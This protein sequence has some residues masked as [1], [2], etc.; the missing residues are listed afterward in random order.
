MPTTT[1]LGGD[2]EALPVLTM[3]KG[4]GGSTS[5][6]GERSGAFCAVCDKP[7]ADG[8]EHLEA[9]YG[10]VHAE[11]CSHQAKVIS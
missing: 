11:P 1:M 10:P 2:V 7:I 9:A 5:P 3:P 8:A 4:R 6:K